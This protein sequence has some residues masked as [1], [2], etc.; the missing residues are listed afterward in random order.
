MTRGQVAQFLATAEQSVGPVSATFFL[1]LARTGLRLGEARA[2][3]WDDL[4]FPGRSIHVVPSFSRGR[5]KDSP[6]GNRSRAV[7][8][9]RQLAQALR[10]LEVERKAETLRHGRGVN[11]AAIDRLDGGVLR[12]TR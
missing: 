4:D 7:D 9:S 3:Q 11:K 10:R 8:M 12:A 1:L 6:K 5:L 2:R